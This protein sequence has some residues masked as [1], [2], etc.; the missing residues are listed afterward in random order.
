[1]PR[2]LQLIDSFDQGGSERQALDQT[3]RLHESGKYDVCLASLKPGGVLRA[4]IDKLNLGEIPSYPLKSFY[5]PSAISQLRRLVAHL[6]K[7]KIDL[8]HTHDYYTNIFGMAAGV[9]AGVKVRIASRRETSGMRTGAQTQ[10]QKIA[11]ACAHQI[12]ANSDSVRQ[13][14]IDEGIE[15]KRITVIHSGLDVDRV[16]TP[17]GCSREEILGVLGVGRSSAVPRRFVTIVANMRHEVKDHPMFLRA[18][19]RVS[20]AMPEVGFLLAGEGKLQESLKQLAAELGLAGNAF[21]LG[22]SDNIGQLLSVSDVCVLSSRAEGFSSSILEYMAARR[23]VVATDVGGAREAIIE[24]ETGYTVPSG[25]DE[26][27]AERIISL[28]RDPAKARS[29][30]EQGRRVVEEK[31]SSQ[32]LLRNTEALYERLLTGGQATMDRATGNSSQVGKAGLPP[33]IG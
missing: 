28:L 29:M 13:T 3:R 6:R 17:V 23:P 27:M 1:M 21:F 8:L 32:A 25:N 24:N 14:L 15:S 2:I 20:K 31:F 18:A 4:E 16:S 12:V 11:Y 22:R 19:Q 9:L 7:S 33:L 26:L 30:G 5:G 10:L